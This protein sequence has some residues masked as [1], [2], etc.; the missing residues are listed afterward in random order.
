M[1]GATFFH[2]Q[3]GSACII[4]IHAPVKGATPISGNHIPHTDFNPRTREG[5]DI[6]TLQYKA[7]KLNFN[8]RTREGCDSEIA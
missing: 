7:D 2:T 1:K 8:P 4:L 6:K 5:C 3:H